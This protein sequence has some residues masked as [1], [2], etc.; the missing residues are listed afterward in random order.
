MLSLSDGAWR[1]AVKGREHAGSY[2]GTKGVV[3]IQECVCLWVLRVCEQ[4]VNLC[5]C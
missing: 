5:T 3:V 4:E 1:L 2:C